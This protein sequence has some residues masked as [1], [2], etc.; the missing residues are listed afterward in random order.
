M[1]DQPVIPFNHAAIEGNEL[2]YMAESLRSGHT[3][4]GG[5]FSKRA[6]RSCRRPPAPRRSCS[7]P[8]AP[9][10]WSSPR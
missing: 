10:R 4:A 2:E 7:P 1:S 9:P 6:G 8:R 5:G 3:S